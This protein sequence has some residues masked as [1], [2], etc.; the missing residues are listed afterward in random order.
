MRLAEIIQVQLADVRVEEAIPYLDNTLENGGKVGSGLEKALKSDAAVR[1]VPIHPDLMALGFG[2]FVRRRHKQRKGAGRLFF[3]VGYG[4]DG[5][6]STVFSKKFAW[7]L[8]KVGLSDPELVFHSFR[9][10]AEDALKNACQH[11]YLIDRVLGHKTQG[12]SGVY[13]V[14]TELEVNYQAVRAMK[15]PVDLPALLKD[16]RAEGQSSS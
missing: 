9:H 7:T 10:L 8:D 13:G 6:P 15:L 14:G 1:Q 16:H 11:Q 4:A 12:M 2:E 3:E 5:V